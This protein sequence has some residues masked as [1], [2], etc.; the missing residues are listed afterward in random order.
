M[1]RP[2]IRSA[3]PFLAQREQ[4]VLSIQSL[5]A[6]PKLGA[7]M[8]R[9]DF[10]ASWGCGHRRGM[11]YMVSALGRY[12]INALHTALG[13]PSWEYPGRFFCRHGPTAN[14]LRTAPVKFQFIDQFLSLPLEGKVAER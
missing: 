6:P 12:H 13:A 9:K 11:I 5:P 10:S 2:G 7:N 14:A 4:R 1:H 3:F 8:R